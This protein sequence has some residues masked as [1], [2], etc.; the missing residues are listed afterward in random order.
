MNVRDES[1][2][3]IVLPERRSTV[4]RVRQEA[5]GGAVVCGLLMAVFIFIAALMLDA[6]FLLL[7]T[8]ATLGMALLFA[9]P[10]FRRHRRALRFLR[11]APELYLEGQGTHDDL[12]RIRGVVAVVRDDSSPA[13][14]VFSAPDEQTV[15]SQDIIVQSD[16]ALY[17]I[18]QAELLVFRT[19]KGRPPGR[20]LREMMVSDAFE[21][22]CGTRVVVL[23]EQLETVSPPQWLAYPT[24][25]SSFRQRTPS[26]MRLAG[27]SG[28]PLM[29][30]VESERPLLSLVSHQAA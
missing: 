6:R 27:T 25:R 4:V 18:E 14:V 20:S 3:E 5:F 15:H 26:V 22:P 7:S 28:R 10:G 11:R 8:L 13:L 1:G 30:L 16:D 29:I 24:R 9:A 2:H 12:H 19:L 21:V 23:A 17:L